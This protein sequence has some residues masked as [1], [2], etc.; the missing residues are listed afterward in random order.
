MQFLPGMFSKQRVW[1]ICSS[2]QSG[3][4]HVSSYEQTLVFYWVEKRLLRMLNK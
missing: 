3:I 4:V 2:V 1:L